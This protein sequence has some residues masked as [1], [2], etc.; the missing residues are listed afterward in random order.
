MKRIA[1]F[2]FLL[3]SALASSA[4]VT[5]RV[6]Y[7]GAKPTISDF[8]TSFTSARVQ[9]QEE[10]D[11]YDE[12]FNALRDVWE[13]H[14]QGKPLEEEETLIVDERNGYVCYQ[15]GPFDGWLSRYELCFWNESDGRHKVF[16]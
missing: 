3:C 16:A 4:Q 8:V 5:F 15:R 14:R 13:R 10:Y 12:S 9:T 7:Q 11:E 1:L 2:I 6:S